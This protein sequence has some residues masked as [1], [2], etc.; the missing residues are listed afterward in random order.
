MESEEAVECS[1]EAERG[2]DSSERGH[3][4]VGNEDGFR[5]SKSGSAKGRDNQEC[6]NTVEHLN[7]SRGVR[8]GPEY[9]EEGY[10]M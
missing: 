5:R 9:R 10:R 2:G 3:P 4:V 1:N 7:K 6:K 8:G